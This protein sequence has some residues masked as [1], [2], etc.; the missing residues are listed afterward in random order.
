MV[1]NLGGM[2]PMPVAMVVS[3]SML[4]TRTRL[5]V[6]ICGVQRMITWKI[7]NTSFDPNGGVPFLTTD[8]LINPGFTRDINRQNTAWNNWAYTYT[9]T[10]GNKAWVPTL[11]MLSWY[12]G[13]N[14]DDPGRG[15]AIYFEFGSIP[16]DQIGNRLGRETV[17]APKCPT[18]GRWYPGTDRTGTSAGN[19]T[20]VLK[21]PNAGYPLMTA[22]ESYFLQA[23]AYVT[24]IVI[25]GGSDDVTS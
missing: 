8:A 2:Q 25:P 22:A 16:S 15:K 23:E 5:A 3:M 24:G 12:D 1:P 19:S 7:T 10:A 20:G 4:P 13:T 9:G 18:G 14:L 17:D 11:W 6:G 21:G